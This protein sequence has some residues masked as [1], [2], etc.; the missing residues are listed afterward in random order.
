MKNKR[1]KFLSMTLILIFIF[2]LY[3]SF[4]Y[5]D[6]FHLKSR[7]SSDIL[8]YISILLCVLLS[9]LSGSD[10]LS[11]KDLSLLHFG[12]IMTAIA[13]LCL[14]ILDFFT[15]GVVVFCIV[16][17]TYCIRYLPNSVHNTV[18]NF[19]I[20]FVAVIF[21]FFILG[22]FIKN[23]DIL[24]IVALFYATCLTTSVYRAVS[25]CINKLFPSPNRYFIAF[26]MILF[27][28]C[29]INVALFNI[30]SYINPAYTIGSLAD[31]SCTLI[32]LFYLPSQ[33][34]IALSGYDMNKLFSNSI[35]P[36]S[37]EALK[38]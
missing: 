20:N 16:Q 14:L 32:W 5:V 33:V 17:I 23:L 34:L 24:L 30:A 21:I 12:M 11:S 3:I 22:I 27:L 4:L 9:M 7:I 1:L 8:K 26:G 2:V 18:K 38:G 6:I 25:A 10:A 28:L 29:D 37:K 19:M 31:I 13:D 35:N 15:V 36:K